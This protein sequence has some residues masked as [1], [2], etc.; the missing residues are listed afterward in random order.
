MHLLIGAALSFMRVAAWLADIPRARPVA[1]HSLCSQ[2]HQD[3][4]EAVNGGSPAA[5]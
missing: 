5:S 4:S 3:D 1:P 2:E